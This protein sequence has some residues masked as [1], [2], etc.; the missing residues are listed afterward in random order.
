[1][2]L[3]VPLSVPLGVSLCLCCL[4]ALGVAATGTSDIFNST[5]S[6][7]SYDGTAAGTTTLGF[8]PGT[9]VDSAESTTTLLAASL[10]VPLLS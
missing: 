3:Y 1:M 8:P 10:S 9:G 5:T 6:T 7:G 4:A 2:C